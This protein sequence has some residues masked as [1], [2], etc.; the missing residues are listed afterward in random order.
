VTAVAGCATPTEY[1]AVGETTPSAEK[2]VIHCNGLCGTVENKETG[3]VHELKSNIETAHL[4][5][6]V[7]TIWV[8]YR[9]A[10]YVVQSDIYCT[11]R[12][13]LLEPGHAYQVHKKAET[14]YRYFGPDEYT[15]SLWV[16]D[17][18]T[19]TAVA[20]FPDAKTD[21]LDAHGE[22]P[23]AQKQL[24]IYYL[25]G[26]GGVEIDLMTAYLWF[27]LA[28]STGDPAAESLRG[29]VGARVI[30]E[31]GL[32]DSRTRTWF[33]EADRLVVEWDPNPAECESL[34]VAGS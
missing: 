31:Y 23:I 9:G 33:T 22:D 7:Y 4:P 28:A 11:L 3:E 5:G 25:N 8:L 24:G 15:A 12:K 13:V 21:C 17:M 18:T 20:Q 26:L 29:I 34:P 2:V 16:E 1:H 27:S 14:K 6:G 30:K 10:L 32:R 19:G